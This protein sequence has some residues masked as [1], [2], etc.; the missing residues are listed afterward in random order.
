M[1]SVLVDEDRGVGA[2]HCMMPPRT[3]LT[4]ATTQDGTDIPLMKDELARAT[5]SFKG[6]GALSDVDANQ[7]NSRLNG[8]RRPLSSRSALVWFRRAILMIGTTQTAHGRPPR[9]LAGTERRIV[10]DHVNDQRALWRRQGAPAR[11]G[12]PPGPGRAWSIL[13]GGGGQRSESCAPARCC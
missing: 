11:A 9:G 12:P 5:W 7:N 10:E 6:H 2:C 8:T 3:A 13:G 1:V 4:G